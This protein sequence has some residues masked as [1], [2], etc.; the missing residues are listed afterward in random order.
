MILSLGTF[1]WLS[2]DKCRR[3]HRFVPPRPNIHLYCFFFSNGPAHDHFLVFLTTHTKKTKNP[4]SKNLHGGAQTTKVTH[5]HGLSW[6]SFSL[7]GI[8]GTEN[9]TIECHSRDCSHF[10]TPVVTWQVEF[11]VSFHHFRISYTSS[12]TLHCS[13]SQFS[14]HTSVFLQLD[15]VEPISIT[16]CFRHCSWPH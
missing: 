5:D 9:D 6:T 15:V 8:S 11:I 14:Q 12:L 7:H 2:S 10:T 13:F 16:L 4:T 3:D 1:P